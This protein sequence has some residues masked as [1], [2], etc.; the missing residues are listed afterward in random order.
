MDP[1]NNKPDM[2]SPT[3]TN[4]SVMN[5]PPP[6]DRSPGKRRLFPWIFKI[7]EDFIYKSIH[8]GKSF[9]S[10]WLRLDEDGTATIKA[11]S[12]GYAWDGCAPKINILGLFALGTPDGHINVETGKPLTP[13]LSIMHSIST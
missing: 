6:R 3:N 9:N 7:K 4:D 13:P 11:T 1:P 2:P 12:E 5:Y 10:K 8:F